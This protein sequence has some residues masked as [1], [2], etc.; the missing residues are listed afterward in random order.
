[1]A[2]RAARA[3]CKAA[4]QARLPRRALAGISLPD[5]WHA[6]MPRARPH[7]QL[8]DVEAA[9]PDALLGVQQ[10]GLPQHALAL[11]VGGWV[12]ARGSGAAVSSLQTEERGVTLGAWLLL[13]PL[14][15]LRA[16]EGEQLQKRS[17]DFATAHNNK[18]D[19]TKTAVLQ[20]PTAHP[21]MYSPGSRACHRSPGPLSPRPGSWRHSRS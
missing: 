3:R 8:G 17:L 15:F 9:E 13:D 1:L 21:P 16:Q 10:G 14:C 11:K 5:A 12:V 7:L 20:Q 6:P 4:A 18:N 2:E 19:D